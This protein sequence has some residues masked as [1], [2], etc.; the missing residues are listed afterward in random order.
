METGSRLGNEVSAKAEAAYGDMSQKIDRQSDLVTGIEQSL[1][2]VLRSVERHIGT[3]PPSPIADAPSTD[4]GNL[5]VDRVVGNTTRLESVN[6][7]L[8]VLG[9]LL[10]ERL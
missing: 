3:M 9:G 1:I 5:L 6:E 4:I 10:E 7:Q 2:R 8:A